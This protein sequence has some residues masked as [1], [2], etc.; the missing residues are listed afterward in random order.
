MHT[1]AF[2]EPSLGAIAPAALYSA[3]LL[4]FPAHEPSIHNFHVVHVVTIHVCFRRTRG[5]RMEF[6]EPTAHGF[7]R[8]MKRPA[9]SAVRF[10]P[11]ER[12]ECDARDLAHYEDTFILTK[13]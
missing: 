7:P 5:R 4:K 8:L 1:E 9:F 6:L 3:P 2:C 10:L 13:E 12:I 11:Q